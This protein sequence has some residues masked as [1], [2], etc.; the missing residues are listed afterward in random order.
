MSGF[1]IR[2]LGFIRK[3][4]LSILRQPR[5]L[6]SLILGPFFILLI[7]GIGYRDTVRVRRTIFVVPEDSKIASFVDDYSDRLGDQI[8]YLGTTSTSEEATD[9]LRD[10]RA[11]LVVITPPNPVSDWESNEQSIF[12]LMHYEI[13]PFEETVVNVLGTRYIEAIN[14][15]VLISLADEG[16]QD[17][18]TW[19]EQVSDAKQQAAAVRQALDSGDIEQANQAAASLE[20]E[21]NVLTS[22]VDTGLSIFSNAQAISGEEE[23]AITDSIQTQLETLK[24]GL[25]SLGGLDSSQLDVTQERETVVQIENQLTELDDMLTQ[26][27]E[28][29]SAVLVSPFRSETQNVTQVQFQPTHY[30]VPAVIALLIQHICVTLAGLSIV[31]EKREG[32]MELFRA[33]P[34]TAI[35]TLLGKYISFTLLVAALGAAL[36]ALVVILLRVPMLGSWLNYSLILLGVIFTSLGFGFL[37]SVT[38]Q[39]Q[40]QTVQLAM[41]ML[42]ASIF[43]SGFFLPLY[44]IWLPVQSISWLLPATYG[45]SLLQG[46]MLR[47]LS[48]NYMLLLILLGLGVLLFLLCWWRLGRMMANE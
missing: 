41:I 10:G 25:D 33:A 39:T 15:Q 23:D 48:I 45:I 19:Q 38:S 21:L 32:M 8:E 28:I 37:I 43:F 20:E 40:S 46:V 44:R 31:N 12:R 29:D 30:Y 27:R 22:A 24:S 11:D 2:V 9:I 42:L 17:A 6:F 34:L 13:D 36:T 5:L 4:L 7:F 47:G 3:E 26:F 1:F 35:E 18:V 14:R 16:K